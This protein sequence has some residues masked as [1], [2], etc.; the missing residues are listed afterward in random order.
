MHKAI[1]LDHSVKEAHVILSRAYQLMGN[2]EAALEHCRQAY[3]LG[4]TKYDNAWGAG[5]IYLNALKLDEAIECLR[6]AL[7]LRPNSTKVHKKLG[8]V[9][10]LKG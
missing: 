1:A 2:E 5:I 9:L 7:E 4:S 8:S 6:R 10:C 3:L